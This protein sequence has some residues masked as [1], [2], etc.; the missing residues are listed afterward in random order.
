MFG[1]SLVRPI[2]IKMKKNIFIKDHI[3]LPKHVKISL[4]DKE[5][6]F[7]KYNITANELPKIKKNDSAIAKL[8]AKAGDIVKI[9]RNSPTAGEAL[10]YRCVVNV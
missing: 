9:I 7:K 8:N 2:F 5:E 3:L 1:V 6:L 10:F 4:K